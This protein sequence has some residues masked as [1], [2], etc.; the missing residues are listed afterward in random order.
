MITYYEILDIQEYD[1]LSKLYSDIELKHAIKNVVI[2]HYTANSEHR[3]KP[4]KRL[5]PPKSY[6]SYILNSPYK[7]D[8]LSQKIIKKVFCKAAFLKNFHTVGF[9]LHLSFLF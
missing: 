6:L 9:Y 1:W 7:Y 3:E 2:I 8:W 4:W 5:N